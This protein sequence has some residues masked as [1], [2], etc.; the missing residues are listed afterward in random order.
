MPE[1]AKSDE[2]FPQTYREM[3]VELWGRIEKL[4]AENVTRAL[5]AKDMTDLGKVQGANEAYRAV[6]GTMAAIADRHE[7]NPTLQ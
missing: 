6:V 3:W 2:I 1:A 7:V 5:S 4:A